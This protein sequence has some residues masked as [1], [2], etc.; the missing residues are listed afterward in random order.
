MSIERDAAARP[1]VYVAGPI[2]GDPWGCV[3]KAIGASNTLHALGM[4][5][6]LPQL[7]VLHEM[8]E[9]QPY[10]FWIEHGMVMLGR[11]DGLFRIPGDS[12]GADLETELALELDIPVWE[13]AKGR[14][15][16]EFNDWCDLVWERANS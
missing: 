2:T 3:R 11:C 9:P 12:P 13:P 8:V 6:Y 7:S 14:T 16:V 10:S 1:L 4:T 5:A 15:A